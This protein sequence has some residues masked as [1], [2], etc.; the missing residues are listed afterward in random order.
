MT[1]A[2]FFPSQLYHAAVKHIQSQTEYRPTVGLVLG[3][4]LSSL[5]DAIES[6]DIIP[7]SDIP[8]WP[9]STVSGHAGR[10]VIGNL[11]GQTVLVMQGRSHFY[12]GH[13]IHQITLP[14]RVMSLLGIETY[15]VTNAAGGMNPDFSAG[16]LML[17]RDHINLPGMA[18]NN[19]LR[20]PNATEFG[21]RFPD[22]T[23]PYDADLRQL[24]HNTADDLGFELR[25]GVYVFVAGPSY[26]TPA[27][28]R[29]LRL[30]GGDA[31]G[32]STVP[33]VVVARHAGLRV[34]GISTITNMAL[35]DPPLGTV[36]SHEEVLETGEKILPRLSALIQAIVADL[37]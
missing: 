29:Y 5:A 1:Q 16:D 17:I 28:L 31:V 14:V 8:N 11:S 12:E 35:P 22:M 33:S 23:T 4:G 30:I 32:M 24:A 7:Y 26:E 19:P 9:Q 6:P 37:N 3:S 20:G 36:L 27:E 34:L 18:G 21:P 2:S 10:L 25:E 15:L 13:P